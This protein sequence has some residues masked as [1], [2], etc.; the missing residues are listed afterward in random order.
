MPRVIGSS[1]LSHP[2]CN[3][4]RGQTPKQYFREFWALKDISF[5]IKKGETVGIIGR[6]GSGKSTLL[7]LIC[8]TLTPTSG[9]IQVTGRVTAMLELGSGFNSDFTGHENIIMNARI[10]GMT[11]MEIEEKYK[12]IVDFADIGDFID[13][14][15]KTYSSGMIVRLAFATQAALEP[16]ILVVDEALAVGDAEFQIRCFARMNKLKASGTTILFVS[17]DIATIRSFCDR[18]IYISAGKLAGFGDVMEMT[19]R[20]QRDVMKRSHASANGRGEVSTLGT[21]LQVTK[22]FLESDTTKVLSALLGGQASFNERAEKDRR[23]TGRVSILSL[24]L[25]NQEGIPVDVIDPKE[26]IKACI[27]LHSHQAIS[28]DIHV[29]LIVKD[30]CGSPVAG[31]RDSKF[32]EPQRFDVDQ[33]VIGEMIFSLP[34]QAGTYY[35]QIGLLLFPPNTKYTGDFFNFQSAEISDLVEYGVYFNVASWRKHPTSSAVLIES[36]LTLSRSN[37]AVR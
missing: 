24:M 11:Q 12:D 17:H 7:Q 15:V 6:N 32:D 27:L 35:M 13:Q 34:L 9:D 8:N 3:A 30:K 29:G 4:W 28:A 31:I 5:E 10:L 14:P 2:S 33:Y 37:M 26:V 20:Y 22:H 1:S 16:D 21:H 25:L 18:A 19:D 23:G 36:D